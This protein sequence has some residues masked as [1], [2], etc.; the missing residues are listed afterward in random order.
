MGDSVVVPPGWT[1][2]VDEHLTLRLGTTA[3]PSPAAAGA[4]TEAVR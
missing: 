3:V 1:A 2:T 4:T